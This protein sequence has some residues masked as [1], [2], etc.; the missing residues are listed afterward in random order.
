MAARCHFSRP[1][2]TNCN[3]G[4]AMREV[5]ESDERILGIH[6]FI[7]DRCKHEEQTLDDYGSPGRR[8]AFRLASAP[9]LRRGGLG[10]NRHPLLFGIVRRCQCYESRV[11]SGTSGRWIYLGLF[12]TLAEAV[13][14]RD[15]ALLAR[16]KAG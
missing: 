2:C 14:A 10:I 13:A 9:P 11:A 8:C 7:C 15:R 6:A 12:K 1:F 4:R 16:R 5:T 3:N